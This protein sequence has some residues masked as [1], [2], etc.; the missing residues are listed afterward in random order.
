MKLIFD[1]NKIDSNLEHSINSLIMEQASEIA[2][3]LTELDCRIWGR[4]CYT[5]TIDGVVFTDRAQDIFNDYYDEQMS[6]L[7][8]LINN[9]LKL[10]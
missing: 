8:K 1:E 9:Q 10:I 4:Q 2:E 5:E 7:Y 6:Q 3:K